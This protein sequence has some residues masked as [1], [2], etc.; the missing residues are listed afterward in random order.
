MTGSVVSTPIIPCTITG[1]TTV[2]VG[3]DITLSGCS[4][5]CGWSSSSPGTATVGSCSG[6]VHGV[7]AG[8]V[9]IT[10]T[11]LEGCISTYTVTVNPVCPIIGPLSVCLGQTITLTSPCTG[12][13]W[14]SSRTSVA[15]IAGTGVLTPVTTGTTTVT[16]S[17]LTG[18][19]NSVVVT[20]NTVPAAPV[21]SGG[22]LSMCVGGTVALTGTATGGTWMLFNLGTPV[23]G[24]LSSTST[25]PT[26]FTGT[27]SGVQEV[28]YIVSNACGSNVAWV[29]VSVNVLPPISGPNS[30]CVGS[31]ITLTEGTTGNWSSSTGAA[32]VSP[33]VGVS[34]TTVHGVTPGVTTITF[35]TSAGCSTTWVVSVNANP[36][37]TGIFAYCAYASYIPGL[38]GS[39]SGGSWT[40]T[41]TG[42]ASLVSLSAS[43]SPINAFGPGTET[44]TY[45]TTAGCHSSAVVTINPIPHLT[46][47][48]SM[49]MGSSMTLTPSVTGPGTPTWT[50]YPGT[51]ATISGGVVT[52]P[53]TSGGP[54]VENISYSINGCVTY[55]TITINPTPVIGGP[56]DVC[57]GASITEPISYGTGSWNLVP[58][59]P[60]ATNAPTGGTY[61]VVTGHAVG[62]VV[63]HFTG[64]TGCPA[65]P[66]TIHVWGLPNPGTITVVPGEFCWGS[67]G[68]TI[69][70]GGADPGGTWFSSCTG[71]TVSGTHIIVAPWGSGLPTIGCGLIYTVTSTHGCGS[72][73]SA[74]AFSV[75]ACIPRTDRHTEGDEMSIITS[76]ELKV[77][78]NPNQGTFTVNLLSDKNE[79]ADVKITN[80]VGETVKK[81]TT[82]TNIVNEVKINN[83]P[84]IYLVMVTTA[85]GSYVAKVVAE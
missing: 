34:S 33:S 38:T 83:A 84:G 68:A 57:I 18:C 20:V 39:P 69:T 10:F 19:S 5:T 6:D 70:M 29:F 72:R 62:T 74:T 22:P 21:I 59:S 52:A 32:T 9:T 14:T 8:V 35:T 15:T 24:T 44:F 85:H 7:T 1:P 51:H 30:V 45:T 60:Y 55:Y 12:G 80:M 75:D 11:S 36:V 13:V 82:A 41:T 54:Y 65:A 40:E 56:S 28:L 3:S 63:L 2:C 26:T 49:C 67:P 50:I 61:T 79:S 25:D 48:T 37:I 81:F 77:F 43:T 31:S 53:V 17:S 71:V 73:A 16:F 58:V 46:G 42:H 23:C 78:P 76:P 27:A 47:S 66:K 64:T 4:G